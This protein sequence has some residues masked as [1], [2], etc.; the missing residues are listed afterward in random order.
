[1]QSSLLDAQHKICTLEQEKQ[2]LST[3]LRNKCTQMARMKNQCAQKMRE[4]SLTQQEGPYSR[5]KW[6][7][8]DMHRIHSVHTMPNVMRSLRAFMSEYRPGVGDHKPV[9]L[10]AQRCTEDV[11]PTARPCHST[12]SHL[13]VCL[14]H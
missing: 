10:H 2:S 5:C 6:G 11:P 1:V 14:H 12:A 7:C 4:R 13:S 9:A 3:Q 8:E